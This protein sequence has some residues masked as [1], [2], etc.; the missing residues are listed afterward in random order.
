MYTLYV[1]FFLWQHRLLADQT[2]WYDAY[3]PAAPDPTPD[4][5]RGPLKTGYSMYLIWAQILTADFF[6]LPGCTQWFDCRL[7]CSPNLDTL[8]LT[9]NIIGLTTGVTR[10]QGMFTPPRHL[11]L[12]S[13]LSGGPC[14]PTLD[15]AID[16]ILHIVYFAILY[17]N[18]VFALATHGSSYF[19]MN[20]IYLSFNYQT[21]FNHIHTLLCLDVWHINYL[22]VFLRCFFSNELP[23]TCH[24]WCISKRG[25]EIT[26][27]KKF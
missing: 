15:F 17:I 24:Y 18:L 26:Y 2:F 7:F 19:G 8:N 9:S 11:I 13:H 20:C 4:V 27:S 21:S 14:C 6:R 16:Y 5:Y 25:A 1:P 10:Q 3:S 23:I 12:P 22:C